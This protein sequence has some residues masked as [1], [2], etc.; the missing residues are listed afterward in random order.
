MTLENDGGTR[1]EFPNYTF[2]NNTWYYITLVCTGTNAFSFFVNGSFVGDGSLTVS[3]PSTSILQIGKTAGS[4]F[5]QSGIKV[6][7]VHAY[8]SALGSS[9]LR[10]NFLASNDKY[11]ARIYGANYT[12]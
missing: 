8:S 12:A 2:S 3:G 7:H 1:L 11:D 4:T 10:R 9:A 5:T 6:G